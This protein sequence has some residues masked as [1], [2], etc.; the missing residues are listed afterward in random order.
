VNEQFLHVVFEAISS[1]SVLCR[2]VRDVIVV[3]VVFV[4]MV[5]VWSRAK[6][7]TP[8][9]A[10][11]RMTPAH[12]CRFACATRNCPVFVSTLVT[13]REAAGTKRPEPCRIPNLPFFINMQIVAKNKNKI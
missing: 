4:V 1:S 10:V 9:R 2:N 7:L 8:S 3:D 6:R 5:V 13:H 11:G 12:P